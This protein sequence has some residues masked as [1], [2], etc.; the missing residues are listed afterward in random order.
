MEKDSKSDVSLDNLD[1]VTVD[2]LISFVGEQDYVAVAD[3][4]DELLDV[5]AL[6]T[7]EALPASV[8]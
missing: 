2:A 6:Q 5:C 7:A 4:L 8:D 3:Q 1:S